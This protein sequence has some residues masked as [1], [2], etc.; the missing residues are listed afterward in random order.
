MVT[1]IYALFC[2]FLSFLLLAILGQIN[3]HYIPNEE[4]LLYLTSSMKPGVPPREMMKELRTDR[5][6]K[7]GKTLS[8]L[9]LCRHLPRV[10]VR[11]FGWL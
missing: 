1:L 9:S 8:Q 10:A 4:L 3:C 5:A 2:F 6:R 11:L 7:Y